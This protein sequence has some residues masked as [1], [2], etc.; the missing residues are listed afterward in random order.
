MKVG[1]LKEIPQESIRASIHTLNLYKEVWQSFQRSE[2]RNMKK[3]SYAVYSTYI[4][5]VSKHICIRFLLDF[6]AMDQFESRWSVG[7]FINLM[8]LEICFV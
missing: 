2:W 1:A 6:S 3:V 5:S 4:F 8:S 7:I